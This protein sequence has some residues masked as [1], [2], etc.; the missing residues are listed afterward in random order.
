[1]I[2]PESTELVFERLDLA[3][4]DEAVLTDVNAHMNRLRAESR[5]HDP[6]RSIDHTRATFASVAM[7]DHVAFEPWIARRGGE[8]VGS[9]FVSMSLKDNLHM[10]FLDLGVDADHRRAGV[11]SA[12]LRKGAEIAAAADRVLL[13]LNTVSTVPAGAA[14]LERYGATAGLAAHT[15]QLTIADVD[16]AMLADW[17]GSD[18]RLGDFELLVWEGPYPEEHLEAMV[19]VNRVMNQQPFDDLDVEEF[20]IDAEQ[21]RQTEAFLEARNQMRW[22]MVAR[23]LPSGDL[24]GFTDVVFDP[25]DPAKL[26]QGNT[27]V[28]PAYRG[29]G[30]GKWLKAAMLTKVLAERPE[31]ERVRTG[32]ADS[33][34]AML[35]INRRLG[36]EPYVAE[37]VWQLPLERVQGV[38]EG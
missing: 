1:M 38:G 11:G 29:N 16:R 5:P 3:A 36:F 13:L 12:L 28:D 30:L 21:L 37:T 20:T 26:N 19:H 15:N 22:T 27:G 34:E 2:A 32:N 7:L 23:H 4:S 33:N 25:E 18:A 14:F 24:A 31:V 9:L 6:P 10:A 8:L 35:A 17:H